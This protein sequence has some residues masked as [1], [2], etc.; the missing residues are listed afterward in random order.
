M[1]SPAAPPT[2]AD[3]LDRLNAVLLGDASRLSVADWAA[4]WIAADPSAI[5]DPALWQLLR[6]AASIDVRSP[7]QAGGEGAFLYS[8]ADIRDWVDTAAA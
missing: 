4:G 5:S 3:V 7:S 1:S 6:L 8:D 2:V